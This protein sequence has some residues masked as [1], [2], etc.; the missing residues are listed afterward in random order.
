MP[1]C[2]LLPE[3]NYTGAYKPNGKIVWKLQV[4]L[5]CERLSIP[6]SICCEGVVNLEPY[7]LGHDATQYLTM[8]NTM[9][10]KLSLKNFAQIP[11]RFIAAQDVE[12]AYEQ[13]IAEQGLIA[14]RVP[15]SAIKSDMKDIE[16]DFFNAL[17]WLAWPA[18][19]AKL[20]A[21]HAAALT[22]SSSNADANPS[23]GALR[24]RLTLLDESGVLVQAPEHLWSLLS[25]RQWTS[26]FLDHREEVKTQM[27]VH[28]I[29]HGL[30]QRLQQPFKAITAHAWRFGQT[31]GMGDEFKFEKPIPLPLMGIPDW[32]LSWHQ[33]EQDATFYNDLS[34]FRPLRI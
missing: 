20:N 28:I 2:R 32:H 17:M 7:F 22:K 14:T 27:H 33:G 5:L 34:V 9:A 21:A 29:G 12:G 13:V 19:K 4:A 25:N 31:V 16:H 3:S 30:L 26:L 15:H 24:D 18:L 8:L 10:E 11:I 23:R 1:S 6:E